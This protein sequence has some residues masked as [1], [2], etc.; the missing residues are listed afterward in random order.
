MVGD[1]LFYV[2]VRRIRRREILRIRHRW[3]DDRSY[4]ITEIFKFSSR[5]PWRR[6]QNPKGIRTHV[7]LVKFVIIPLRLESARAPLIEK[8]CKRMSK[9]D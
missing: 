3:R 7:P 4:A 2:Q 1:D 6:F 9:L 5:I 8:T